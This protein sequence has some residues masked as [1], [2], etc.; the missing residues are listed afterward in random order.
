MKKKTK[1]KTANKKKPKS[2]KAKKQTRIEKLEA[3]VSELAIRL[4]TL[5][6]AL[7]AL[8]N[9]QKTPTTTNPWQWPNNPNPSWIWK[10]WPIYYNFCSK[11]YT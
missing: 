1:P 4:K 7:D 6:A 8:A 10:D 3:V 2:T 11:K 9:K 5:E